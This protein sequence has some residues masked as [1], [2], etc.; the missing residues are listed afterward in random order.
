MVCSDA[1]E[2]AVSEPQVDKVC[3]PGMCVQWVESGLK[4]AGCRAS[5]DLCPEGVSWACLGTVGVQ[6]T[7]DRV[8]IKFNDC[9]VNS[10]SRTYPFYGPVC[11]ISKEGDPACAEEPGSCDGGVKCVNVGKGVA[12][13]EGT[14]VCWDGVWTNFVSFHSEDGSACQVKQMDQCEPGQGWCEGDEAWICKD[15]ADSSRCTSFARIDTCAAGTCV[16]FDAKNDFGVSTHSAGCQVAA[17]VCQPGLTATCLADAVVTCTSDG[18]AIKTYS[19]AT[20]Q[21]LVHHLGPH[22]SARPGTAGVQCVTTGNGPD[23]GQPG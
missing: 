5:N 23:G 12:G 11:V 16:E 10:D 3:G 22:C 8:P 18:R 7:P 21:S 6:C 9:A 20:L 1:S 4:N 14:V 15:C 17:E 13:G 19:C 2:V